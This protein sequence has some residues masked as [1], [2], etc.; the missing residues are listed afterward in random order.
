VAL[1]KIDHVEYKRE[2]NWVGTV[3]GRHDGASGIGRS[4]R[5]G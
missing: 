5:S 2:P 4:L 1:Q 3:E